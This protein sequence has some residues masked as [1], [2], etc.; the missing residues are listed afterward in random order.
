[1][2][3]SDSHADVT[4]DPEAGGLVKL[5]LL[6]FLKEVKQSSLVHELKEQVDSIHVLFS[7]MFNSKALDDVTVVRHTA[8]GE[9]K[10]IQEISILRVQLASFPQSRVR[11]GIYRAKGPL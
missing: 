11:Q 10:T 7:D 3:G 4:Q 9:P 8:L 2:H 5:F 1:M 6:P